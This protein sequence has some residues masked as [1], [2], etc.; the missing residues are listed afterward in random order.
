MEVRFSTFALQEVIEAARYYEAEVEGLGKAFLEKIREGTAEIKAY[1]HASRILQG[2]YR[3]FLLSRFP[4]GII[5]QIEDQQIFIA[6]VMHLK[7]KPN[8]WKTL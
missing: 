5:Y 2:D 3:R 1:P 8:Y 7:R 4:Y 6:A